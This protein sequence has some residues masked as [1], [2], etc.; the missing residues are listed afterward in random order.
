MLESFNAHLSTNTPKR[1]IR[2]RTP[3]KGKQEMDKR[4]RN[5]HCNGQKKKG[6]TI[7]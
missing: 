1:V 7:Q 2:I 3:K 5:K 6:Q 4:K